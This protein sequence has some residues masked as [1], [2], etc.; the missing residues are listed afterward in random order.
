MYFTENHPAP[1][2]IAPR[3]IFRKLSRRKPSQLEPT[4]SPVLTALELK[5]REALGA[6]KSLQEAEYNWQ[7]FNGF[8]EAQ[9]AYQERLL[10]L[11]RTLAALR[12]YGDGA[13]EAMAGPMPTDMGRPGCPPIVSLPMCTRYCI[14]DGALENAAHA[15][16]PYTS[17]CNQTGMRPICVSDSVLEAAL[18][19]PYTLPHA[20]S[21]N[22]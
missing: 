19:S 16:D 11:Q 15:I 6:L 14:S 17:R 4:G 5:Y 21:G 18:V 2:E 9:K 13:L 3:K 10:Q 12:I 1:S 20:Q 7:G 8:D 22:C